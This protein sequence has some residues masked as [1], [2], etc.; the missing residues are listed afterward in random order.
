MGRL[1]APKPVK[2]F[3]GMISREPGLFTECTG[4][5]AH[6]FG[7]VDLVSRVIPWDHS[8]YYREEMG[9]G[10]QRMFIF[11]ETLVDPML[12]AAAKHHAISIEASFSEPA[13][14]AVRRR[15][16]LDPGYLTEAK[17]V[18]ATTK[19]FPHRIYIGKSIYAE[20][21]LHYHKDSRS[22]Q[23]VEHTYPDFR[24]DYCLNLFNEARGILRSGLRR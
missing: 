14:T 8:E 13:E 11:F 5:F 19:D 23:P 6:E 2:L 4:L 12:L 9:T 7:P 20:S 24:T 21:T 10:L 3:L 18:L 1:L 15:I 17:V 16:N 22:F